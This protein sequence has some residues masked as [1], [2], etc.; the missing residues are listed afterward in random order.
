M[1]YIRAKYIFALGKL[2]VQSAVIRVPKSAVLFLISSS[3]AQINIL[4]LSVQ[5]RKV[6]KERNYS[7]S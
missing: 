3:A 1:F 7:P 6:V 2:F 4:I 5:A